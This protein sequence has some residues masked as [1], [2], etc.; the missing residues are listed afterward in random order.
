M[1]GN[2]FEDPAIDEQPGRREDFVE[3]RFHRLQQAAV[4]Q[5]EFGCRLVEVFRVDYAPIWRA[6]FT[7]HGL[8]IG[9]DIP[10]HRLRPLDVE[11]LPVNDGRNLDGQRTCAFL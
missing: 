1:N 9:L 4:L 3:P 2:A 6:L 5:V 10:D 7:D 11:A 8:A